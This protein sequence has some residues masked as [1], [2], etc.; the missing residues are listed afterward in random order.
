M[1]PIDPVNKRKSQCDVFDVYKR[2]M[3]PK[4]MYFKKKQRGGIQAQRKPRLI[5]CPRDSSCGC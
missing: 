2:P 1:N 4:N 5:L 3:S